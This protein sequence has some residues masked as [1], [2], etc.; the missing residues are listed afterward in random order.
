MI[1]YNK[2]EHEHEF[3][4]NTVVVNWCLLNS[5]NYRCSYCPEFLHSGSSGNPDYDEVTA[6]CSNVIEHYQGKNIYFDLTG[7]E[8]TYWPDFPNL[9]S[10][11]KSHEDVYVGVISNGSN[12][13][14]WWNNIKKELDHACL[15]FQPEFSKRDHYIKL[16]R[17]ISGHMRTHVNLMM[18]PEYFDLCIEV[19]EELVT[20][21]KNLSVAL[22]P[23]LVDFKDELYKYTDK[24]LEIINNQFELYGSRVKWDVNWPIFRGA[25]REIGD[26]KQMTLSAHSFIS[27]GNNRWKGWKCYTGVEQIVIDTNSQVWRGWCLEGGSLG[28]IEEYV[29]LPEEPI[30][31]GRDY[32]HCNFDI[33]CTKEKI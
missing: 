8:V 31:C 7:G 9:V 20:T 15:S 22:Q 25:M 17:L 16:A 2:L 21:V 24:Q 29:R 4:K 1:K 3:A 19:V 13:L 28:F 11:L 33:M 27:S 10:F 18:H 12:S 26:K 5:C 23:L 14:D 32:C 6:F 30:I